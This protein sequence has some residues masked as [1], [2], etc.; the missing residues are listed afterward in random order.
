M[1]CQEDVAEEWK[2][3]YLGTFPL[4]FLRT[5]ADAGRRYAIGIGQEQE[6]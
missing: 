5:N 2:Q 3:G 6:G 1:S 4:Q